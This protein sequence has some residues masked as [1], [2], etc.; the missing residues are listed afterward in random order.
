[1]TIELATS[2]ADQAAMALARVV[3]SMPEGKVRD[4]QEQMCRAVAEAMSDQR[5]LVASAGTG[6]GKSLA[7][8]IPAT[9]QETPVVVATATKALQ[10]QILEH[11]V[12]RLS[13]VHGRPVNAVVLKGRANYLCP[14]KLKELNDKSGGQQHLDESM[15]EPGLQRIL[16]WSQTT[17]TGDRSEMTFEPSA[18]AWAG[19]SVGSRECPGSKKCPSGS[20]CFADRAYMK[21]Q[22]ADV[23]IVNMHLYLLHS[24]GIPL[25]PPHDNVVLDEAHELEDVAGSVLGVT[26]TPRQ[27]SSLADQMTKAAL[28]RAVADAVAA[29]GKQIFASLKAFS[30]AAVPTPLPL[31]LAGAAHEAK[32]ALLAAHEELGRGVSDEEWES[33]TFGTW[34]SMDVPDRL[35]EQPKLRLVKRIAGVIEDL[36]LAESPP[37]GW[38]MW[39]EDKNGTVREW[40]AAPVDVSEHLRSNI[41]PGTTAILTSAT[42]PLNWAMSWGLA[43]EPHTYL[44]LRLFLGLGL[45]GSAGFMLGGARGLRSWR[46]W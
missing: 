45:L 23:V 7:Y 9:M 18:Q 14:Q 26:L 6:T 24:T 16:E 13:H 1:M 36:Q 46:S 17:L 43:D 5:H 38:A 32:T 3:E 20:I 27:F 40:R 37:K 34:E 44:S 31:D 11:D 10:D 22:R 12:P 15:N 42:I 8:L 39:T 4:G 21:A 25:L 30:G 2:A 28:P 29:A 33:E 41:W 19:V 35:A